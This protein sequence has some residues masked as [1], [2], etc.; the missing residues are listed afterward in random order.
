MKIQTL[1]ID[2]DGDVIIVLRTAN[3]CIPEEQTETNGKADPAPPPPEPVEDDAIP[4]RP[5]SPV[6]EADWVPRSSKKSKKKK[7]RKS[8]IHASSY[9]LAEPVPEPAPEEPIP[10]PA[11]DDIEQAP[12]PVPEPIEEAEPECT[13]EAPPAEPAPV[14]ETP[15]EPATEPGDA[16]APEPIEEDL[17]EGASETTYRIQASGKHLALASPVFKQQVLRAERR[18]GIANLHEEPAEIYAKNWNLEAFLVVLGVIHCQNSQLPRTLSLETLAHVATIA[19]HYQC[20]DAI[21]IL[22]DIWIKALPGPD[23]TRFSPDLTLWLWIAFFF[24]LH[25]YFSQITSAVMSLSDGPVDSLG[26][27]FPQQFLGNMELHRLQEIGKAILL[28]QNTLDAFLN[29]E[30]GCSFE[31]S[32]IMYGALT[33]ELHRVG[34]LS[35]L[36][37]VAP[38][39]GWAYRQ[40][41][42]KVS[43]IKSPTWCTRT[44]ERWGY[45][46]GISQH[47]CDSS[48]FAQ[49]FGHLDDS[50]AG[51]ELQTCLM[52]H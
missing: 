45:D 23:T 51:L 52:D 24:D 41:L 25:D 46:S 43:S 17:E 10:E 31:C 35:P 4:E 44:R 20:K 3:S 27:P 9:A 2:P 49:L 21:G 28:L 22:Q 32:A 36:L 11:V 48:S 34:L 39:R 50:V 16:P 42:E 47:Q 13:E 5:A 8:T 14:P 19:H 1:I 12:E 26:L 38:F 6:Q 15:E 40:L 18:K 29:A 7:G 33:K 37:P 30:H